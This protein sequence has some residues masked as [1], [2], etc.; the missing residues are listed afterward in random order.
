MKSFWVKMSVSTAF[1]TVVS[2]SV[3]FFLPFSVVVNAVIGLVLG[4]LSGCL[5]F[6]FKGTTKCLVVGFKFSGKFIKGLFAEE[7][8]KKEVPQSM[9]S[10]EL[11]KFFTSPFSEIARI[12]NLAFKG[13]LSRGFLFFAIGFSYRFAIGLAAGWYF[14][15]RTREG[16]L[17]VSSASDH[18]FLWVAY[19]VSVYVLVSLAEIVLG[20]SEHGIRSSIVDDYEYNGFFRTDI[21]RHLSSLQIIAGLVVIAFLLFVVALCFFFTLCL[22][23]FWAM[24]EIKKK[25]KLWLVATG[26]IVG[27]IVG[28]CC[29]G[30]ELDKTLIIGALAS[31]AWVGAP[32]LINLFLSKV[33]PWLPFRVFSL[34]NKPV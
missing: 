3:Y 19:A 13:V 21:E 22:T 23:P 9:Y 5:L 12:S 18:F 28:W 17:P 24:V 32:F 2:L 25:S 8:P 10:T 34:V 31:I 1:G 27:S 16:G 33:D 14:W 20:I 29:H 15:Q 7:E 30:L 11:P 26:V 4:I 6:D